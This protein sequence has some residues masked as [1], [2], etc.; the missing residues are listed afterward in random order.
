[1][2]ITYKHGLYWRL[3]AETGLDR[4][5]IRRV[6]IG[7]RGINLHNAAILAKAAGVTIDELWED[8]ETER[9]K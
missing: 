8:I 5:F 3:S 2:N 4:S 1:M 9:R 6:L 7:E